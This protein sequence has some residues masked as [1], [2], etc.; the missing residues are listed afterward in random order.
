MT[1]HTAG[2]SDLYL[3]T[4]SLLLDCEL[5]QLTFQFKTFLPTGNAAKGLG[6]GHVSLEPS[7]LTSVR[8]ASETYLQG[9]LAEWIPIA[10]D[11]G[12]AGSILHYHLS[13]NH[14]L[15]KFTPDVPVIGTLEFNGWSF[16]SG[17]YTDPVI[18]PQKSSGF[19]YFSVGPG[20]RTS[21]CNNLDFG[22]GLAFPLTDPHWGNPLIRTELRILY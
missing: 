22:V 4:K 10:G 15:Y 17:A 18:G 11:Q 2:F 16:Q 13:L 19:S 20:L 7:L 3:G 14:G 1:P 12:F 9:Q 21:V 8:L 6:S 5:M